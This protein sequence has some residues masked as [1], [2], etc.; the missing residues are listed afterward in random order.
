M[1]PRIIALLAGLPLLLAVNCCERRDENVSPGTTSFSMG[2]SEKL[3]V[4]VVVIEGNEY[5]A[6][7]TDNI[8]WGLC[9]KL[10]AKAET[11]VT[12]PPAAP[13]KP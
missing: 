3:N 7:E 4:R 5:L 6:F 2:G 13:A 8:Y 11:T 10:P 1:K 12:L 9:P